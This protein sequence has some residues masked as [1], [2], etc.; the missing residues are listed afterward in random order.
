M[1]CK[2]FSV[3]YAAFILPQPGSVRAHH[4]RHA[5]QTGCRC[6]KALTFKNSCRLN[7]GNL[8]RRETQGHT[9]VMSSCLLKKTHLHMKFRCSDSGRQFSWAPLEARSCLGTGLEKCTQEN[10][11]PT[12][13]QKGFSKGDDWVQARIDGKYTVLWC[14]LEEKDADRLEPAEGHQDSTDILHWSRNPLSWG[15]LLPWNTKE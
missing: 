15:N 11:S 2:Q 8:E 13:D 12:E 6:L 14:L 7:S 5:R 1:I 9:S 3:Q 10:S 4:C